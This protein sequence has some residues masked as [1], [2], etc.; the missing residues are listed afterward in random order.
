MMTFDEFRATGVD[1]DDLGAALNDGMW[2]GIE[3]G[4]GRLYLG[5][6]YIE[7][8]PVA[9]W[10]NMV[11]QEWMLVLGRDDWLSDDL[12]ELEQLLYQFAIEEGYDL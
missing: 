12:V 8:K 9:G 11:G 5:Q 1:C 10:P 2:D 4:R 3:P 6:L 7:R